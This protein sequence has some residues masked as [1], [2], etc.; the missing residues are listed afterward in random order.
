ML[1]KV[2]ACN[3][4][5]DVD[6]LLKAR[7]MH[8]SDENYLKDAFHIYTKNQAAMKRNDT[9]LNNLPDE[10]YVI[11]AGDKITENFLCHFV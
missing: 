9:V 3:I 7:F 1:N 10:P 6:K 8:E 4:D 11:E 2:R 5:N